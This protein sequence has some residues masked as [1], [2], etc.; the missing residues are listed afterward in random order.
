M[1]SIEFKMED[2]KFPHSTQF[3]LSLSCSLTLSKPDTSIELYSKTISSAAWA[4]KDRTEDIYYTSNPNYTKSIHLEYTF[5]MPCYLLFRLINIKDKLVAAKPVSLGEAQCL[6]SEI[7][8]SSGQRLTLNITN[9]AG[10]IGQLV[11]SAEEMV[12]SKQTAYI[13]VSAED[14]EDRSGWFYSYKPFF[15]ISKRC[16]DGSYKQVYI[17]EETPFKQTTWKTMSIRVIDLCDNDYDL[18]LVFLLHDSSTTSEGSIARS[19]FTFRQ[20]YRSNATIQL[21]STQ[22]NDEN[23]MIPGGRVHM[24]LQEMTEDFSFFDYLKGGCKL[25][26]ISAVDFSSST[27]RVSDPN[28]HHHITTTGMND[29]EKLIGTIGD[30][31]LSSNAEPSVHMYGYGAKIA[32]VDSYAFPLTHDNSSQISGVA[33]MLKSYRSSIRFIEPG[34]RNVITNIIDTAA[35]IAREQ[36]EENKK[37]YILLILTSDDISDMQQTINSVIN[38]SSLPLSIL[39]AG[40]GSSAFRNITML[41]SEQQYLAGSKGVKSDRNIVH[42]SSLNSYNNSCI[43]VCKNLLSKVPSDLLEYYRNRDIPPIT[44]QSQP[45]ITSQ[46]PQVSSQGIPYPEL[47]PIEKLYEKQSPVKLPKTEKIE[48]EKEVRKED[49]N[50]ARDFFTM[51]SAKIEQ[52]S[53]NS[54]GNKNEPQEYKNISYGGK[55]QNPVYVEQSKE[56]EKWDELIGKKRN[57]SS[58]EKT[59]QQDEN[60]KKKR[61]SN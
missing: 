2:S 47:P 56:V 54:K 29:F 8:R 25:S 59:N 18:P 12:E 13:S 41:A 38:A 50:K 46:E 23:K 15:S 43:E 34:K 45:E 61:K 11:V 39:I 40:I 27:G 60:P 16:S 1:L 28:Y 4:L 20:I 22:L 21:F 51:A 55:V 36:N 14:L 24:C 3:R 58:R 52:K 57:D 10:S 17:S 37:Y 48:E 7:L 5:G 35:A 19:E 53:S 33:D 44:S 32:G 30:V 31:V 42:F 49:T 9:T 6:L 26:L